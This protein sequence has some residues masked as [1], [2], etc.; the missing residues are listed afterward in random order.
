MNAIKGYSNEEVKSMIDCYVKSI[1]E[2]N[3]LDIEFIDSALHG[4]RLRGTARPDSDLDYVFEYSGDMSEDSVFNIM[5]EDPYYIDGVEIDINPIREEDSGTLDR[6]MIKSAKYDKEMLSEEFNFNY[7]FNALE[8]QKKDPRYNAEDPRSERLLKLNERKIVKVNKSHILNEDA[9][10]AA[11]ITAGTSGVEIYNNGFSYE[12]KPLN[13]NLSQKGNDPSGEANNKSFKHFVGDHVKGYC[14]Y[15]KKMHSGMI[16][17]LYYKNSDSETPLYVYI[18]DFSD[19]SIIPLEADTIRNSGAVDIDAEKIF[20]N[21][22]IQNPWQARETQINQ[23]FAAVGTPVKE[24]I[25]IN[26]DI[27][28]NINDDDFSKDLIKSETVM[29]RIK[30]CKINRITPYLLDGGDNPTQEDIN[31]F[32]TACEIINEKGTIVKLTRIL[33]FYRLIKI[34][35]LA[36]NKQ[37]PPANI[38]L[39]WL[40]VSKLR[41]IKDQLKQYYFS[42]IESVN[43]SS[44]KNDVSSLSELKDLLKSHGIPN[45]II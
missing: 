9:G 28:D 6:Y 32:K 12:I 37:D 11:G 2:D 44:W 35:K 15:D 10:L 30:T 29:Q 34:I 41:N 24:S 36:Y 16:K 13:S 1:I 7:V 5:H 31:N 14:P 25:D 18:Q 17:Y 38:D 42:G 27:D 3:Y 45:V 33:Q 43:I 8:Y 23:D 4:S 26:D 20:K 19:E 40:D 39:S 21:P 22:N